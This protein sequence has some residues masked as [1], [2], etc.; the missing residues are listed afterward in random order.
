MTKSIPLTQGKFALV[1]NE[2]FE[3]VNKYK[4]CFQTRGYA[5]RHAPAEFYSRGCVLYMHRIIMNA[6]D[7]IEVDHINGDK[8]DNRRENLRFANRSQNSRNTPK[9]K[10]G[11]SGFKGVTFVKRL[12]KWK[13]QIEIDNR[14]KYLGVF[15]DKEDAARAYDE[16]AKMYFGEF[17]KLNFPD[18]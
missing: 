8:L 11:T 15:L 13:A 6:P 3:K 18:V 2:D 9:R 4:W 1:D 5:Y 17:A 16:V 12:S 14:G 7:G 10:N